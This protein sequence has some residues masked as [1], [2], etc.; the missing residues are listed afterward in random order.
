[1][2]TEIKNI[3]PYVSD[4]MKNNKFIRKLNKIINKVI[5]NKTNKQLKFRR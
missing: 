3:I 5:L 4:F 2:F 1:M